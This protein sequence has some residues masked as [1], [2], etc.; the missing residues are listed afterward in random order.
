MKSPKKRALFLVFLFSFL[1][2]FYLLGSSTMNISMDA[3][4]YAGLGNRIKE[5]GFPN[6]YVT[7]GPQREPLYPLTIAFSKTVEESLHVPFQ[8]V[9]K[10]LQ[11]LML[12][13]C[14]FAVYLLLSRLSVRDNIIYAAMLYTAVS[15]ALVNAAMSLFSEIA[16]MPFCIASVVLLCASWKALDAPGRGR[17]WG[18]SALTGCAFLLS[19]FTKG[20]FQYVYLVSLAPFYIRLIVAL[21]QRNRLLIRNCLIFLCTVFIL[22]EGGIVSYKALNK[23]VNGHFAFT[24]RV[25]WMLFGSAYKRAQPLTPRIILAHVANIP[26]DGVCRMF[27]TEKECEY[28]SFRS[29]DYY[30]LVELPKQLKNIPE[31]QRPAE[32]SRLSLQLMRDHPFQ[33]LVFMA[34]EGSKMFFWESTMI[35]FVRYPSWLSAVYGNIPFRYGIRLGVAVVSFLGFFYTLGW[36][37]RRLGRF[38]ENEGPLM[39]LAFT[40]L[41]MLSFIT[42]YSFFSVLTRYALPVAPLF[43]VCVA[44]AADRITGQQKRA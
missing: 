20:V 19:A 16:V 42:L 36:G 25:E 44:F 4:S 15:P 7:N 31:E 2:W 6:G 13:G 12:F 24:N 11:I 10:G 18:L 29:T 26:G 5:Q 14:Q 28:C 23:H 38:K 34:L 37:L 41:T 9:Q 22:F 30:G 17:L 1:Y 40:L 21:V 3:A 39:A 32:T 27:F 33:F 43:V 35:G 8:D